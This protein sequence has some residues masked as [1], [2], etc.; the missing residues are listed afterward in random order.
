[1]KKFIFLV[2]CLLTLPLKAS[3]ALGLGG[4][5]GA[6]FPLAHLDG[7]ENEV[8][9]S[10]EGFYRLDPYEVRFHYG[11]QGLETYSV[12]LGI[13]HFFTQSIVRPY[14]EAAFGPTIVSTPG[15]S[16][17]A[18]GVRP[19]GSIGADVGINS[20]LSTG[21]TARYFGMAYFGS[22][23]SGK[24]EANHGFSL[25]GTLLLWF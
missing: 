25:M 3:F 24:F 13:K 10:A 15:R 19:E 21:I 9:L 4:G 20:Y 7:G 17:L 16:N 6:D 8:G 1:M 2:L 23:N 11:N 14:A 5:V 22:T 18:Y 12:V